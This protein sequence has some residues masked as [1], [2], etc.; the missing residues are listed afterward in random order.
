MTDKSAMTK[1]AITK[2]LDACHLLVDSNVAPGTAWCYRSL[3]ELFDSGALRD[4]TA[5]T[6]MT[7]YLAPDVYWLHDPEDGEIFRGTEGD[8]LPYERKIK[9]NRLSVIGLSEHPEDVVIAANKGQSHGCIGNYTMLH[10]IGDDLHLE[11]L[12]IGN[13]CNVDLE[14]PSDPSKNRPKRCKA[15]TQAQL[16]DVVGDRFYAKNCRFVSRL[17]LYPICGA[18]RSLYEN[19]HFESTDDA[20]N[21]NAVYLHCDFDFY[22]GCPISAT[23]DTGSAFLDCRFR[24]CGRRDKSGADQYFMKGQGT[25]YV[26]GCRFEDVREESERNDRPLLVQWTRYPEPETVCYAYHNDTPIGPA[27]HTVDLAGTVGLRAFLT[28]EKNGGQYNI[29]NLLRGMDDWDPLGMRERLDDEPERTWLPVQLLLSASAVEL[30]EEQRSRTIRVTA[31][32]FSGEVCENPELTYEIAGAEENKNSVDGERCSRDEHGQ[33]NNKTAIHVTEQGGE[34]TLC[35]ENNGV[36]V[37]LRRL[38]VHTATGL[39]ALADVTVPPATR[40]APEW[41]ETPTV[42][43]ENGRFILHYRLAQEGAEDASRIQWILARDGLRSCIS[44]SRCGA[45]NRAYCPG[46]EAVGAAVYVRITPQLNCS[47]PGAPVEL[48]ACERLEAS[49]IADPDAIRTDFSDFPTERQTAIRP[50]RWTQDFYT[51]SEPLAEWRKWE[52]ELPETPWVYRSAGNGCVGMGLMPA[53][54]GVQLFYTFAKEAR[55]LRME[56]SLDPAKTSGQGFGSAGQY[57]DVCVGFD[58]VTMTGPALRIL[59]SPEASN[60]VAVFPVYYRDGMAT[61]LG[62]RCYTAGFVTGCHIEAEICGGQL[63]AHLWTEKELPASIEYPSELTVETMAMPAGASVGI[64]HIGTCGAG[65]WHNTV[66]LH[67][68]RAHLI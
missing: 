50:Q 16:G 4:G 43:W 32:Y 13:Y 37:G 66:M 23:D 33:K 5:E 30:T 28:D 27:E 35:G 17:N 55:E 34:L 19:C 57:M 40:P 38:R 11:N 67:E 68:L 53:I 25:V 56:V 22:G 48:C 46:N 41:E 60:A 21:G 45:E 44:T 52:R 9:C 31:K 2:K 26:I 3:N 62:E 49:A 10:F 6:P 29:W 18:K 63:R 47:E 39:T 24:I 8:F 54:Q 61:P 7:V 42:V 12:T 20:L 36:R 1:T 14:Y 59:R 58:A 15:I 65:G 64:L 51:P